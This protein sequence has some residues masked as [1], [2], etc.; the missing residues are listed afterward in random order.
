M[1]SVGILG[2]F[3]WSQSTST[4]SLTFLDDS[5]IQSRTTATRDTRALDSPSPRSCA[6]IA[7]EGAV[8]LREVP[9]LARSQCAKLNES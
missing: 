4:A 6:M 8:V 7:L 3:R 9:W 5:P 2:P 1:C